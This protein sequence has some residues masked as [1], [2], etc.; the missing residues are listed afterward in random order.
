MPEATSHIISIAELPRS[1]SES[2]L[3][4]YSNHT[5]ST[6][7]FYEIAFLFCHIHKDQKGDLVLE[8]RAEIV[9]TWEHAARV[10]DLLN[11]MV[12]NYEA[13]HGLIRLKKE[14]EVEQKAQEPKQPPDKE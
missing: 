11:R 6:P 12:T 4:A 7:G 1:R 9:M 10:R 14:L 2:F 13:E 3:S 8:Q 5:E